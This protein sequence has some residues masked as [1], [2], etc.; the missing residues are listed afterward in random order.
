M[1]ITEGNLAYLFSSEAVAKPSDLKTHGPKGEK[2]FN[3]RKRASFQQILD[4]AAKTGYLKKP[5][6]AKVITT[7]VT[8]GGVLKTS[9]TLN[10]AR[11]S[12]L[13]GL[14]TLVIGLDM[15][16]DIT[17]ALGY[18]PGGEADDLQSAMDQV[19]QT[20]GL[21]DYF[22]GQAGLED[23]I[24][25][26]DL[27]TLDFIPETPELVALEQQLNQKVRREYWLKEKVSD[28]LKN[29]YDLIFFDCSPN[30]S[31]LITNAL[32]ACDVL[33]S[34]L[35][36]KINNFRN[37]KMF[38]SFVKEFKSDLHLDFDHVFV[39]TKL[40]KNRKL[41]REIF[42]WY[43]SQLHNCLSTAFREHNA[44]EEASALNLSIPE[45]K[46]GSEMALEINSLM[47]ELAPFIN[48]VEK[49]QSHPI[50]RIKNIFKERTL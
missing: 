9:L 1:S 16:T 40:N 45:F 31:Q 21:M 29:A 35:E 44:G 15:Q 8:K 25:K 42:E 19:D 49:N 32:V 41:S 47:K 24:Q 30:W 2:V 14:R 11:L 23:L 39:P 43:Q 33:V 27:P 50:E 22:S 3:S 46:P 20:L 10:M 38:A 13:H 48:H 37:F 26:T 7:F 17:S 5:K 34:P 28:P 18:S 4:Q 36:C 12:A 6:Q